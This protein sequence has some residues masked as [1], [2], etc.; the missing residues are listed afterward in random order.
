MKTQG[1]R[2][3]VKS[4]TPIPALGANDM[5]MAWKLGGA[6]LLRALLRVHRVVLENLSLTASRVHNGRTVEVEVLRSNVILSPSQRIVLA[7]MS[8][9]RKR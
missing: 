7:P 3:N 1:G 9:A 6:S 5:L 8:T 4:A 2:T